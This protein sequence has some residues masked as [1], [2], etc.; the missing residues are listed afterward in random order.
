MD[1]GP[2]L[3]RARNGWETL[4]T[5]DDGSGRHDGKDAEKIPSVAPSVKNGLTSRQSVGPK[6][7][8]PRHLLIV[9]LHVPIFNLGFKDFLKIFIFGKLFDE[10]SPGS[11]FLGL[12]YV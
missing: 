4:V 11:Y 7:Q 8:I 12:I 10:I 2:H 9:M 1:G 3:P 6:I 5:A